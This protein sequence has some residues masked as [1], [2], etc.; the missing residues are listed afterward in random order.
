[1]NLASAI[2]LAVVALAVA[3][4]LFYMHRRRR[5]GR[6]VYCSGCALKGV[7]LKENKRQSNIKESN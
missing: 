5:S 4:A 2:V 3:A 7:C 1:M 6:S